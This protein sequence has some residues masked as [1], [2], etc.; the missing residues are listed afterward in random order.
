MLAVESVSNKVFHR[1]SEVYDLILERNLGSK[2]TYFFCKADRFGKPTYHVEVELPTGLKFGKTVSSETGNTFSKVRLE[3][4]PILRGKEIIGFKFARDHYTVDRLPILGY[5]PVR[6][7]Y[8][9]IITKT[10]LK[11]KIKY[12]L[13]YSTEAKSIVDEE[14]FNKLLSIVKEE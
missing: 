6:E 1:L 2:P 11:L 4:T 8:V 9:W 13:T 12:G 7:Y 10:P 5:V 3:L 14:L